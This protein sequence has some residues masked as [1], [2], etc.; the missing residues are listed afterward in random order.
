MSNQVNIDQILAKIA[1]LSELTIENGATQAEANLAA[2]KIQELLDKYS[3]TMDQVKPLKQ[4]TTQDVNIEVLKRDTQRWFDWELKLLNAV[5]Y[6]TGTH[7]VY[8]SHKVSFIGVGQ[9]PIIA[10][11]LY[12]QYRAIAQALAKRAT[13]DYAAKFFDPRSLTGNHSLRN[14]RLSYLVGFSI[15]VHTAFAEAKRANEQAQQIQALVVVKDALIHQKMDLTYGKLKA[16]RSNDMQTNQ[17]AERLGRN[18]GYSSVKQKA[19]EV[20]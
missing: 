3:L 10:K 12:V 5:T 15:G 13:Q 7:Y 8:W 4:H 9:D 18:D 14:Y 6:A 2:S 1:K 11:Q 17:Q 20:K 16:G 19:I